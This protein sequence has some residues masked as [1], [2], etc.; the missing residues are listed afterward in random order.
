MDIID[1]SVSA[2]K[3]PK[4]LFFLF[5]FKQFLTNPL[6]ISSSPS[7]QDAKVLTP[8]M[9]HQ[10]TYSYTK[11]HKW[12][13]HDTL[14][15]FLLS[16]FRKPCTKSHFY[17]FYLTMFHNGMQK[18]IRIQRRKLQCDTTKNRPRQPKTCCKFMFP[19]CHFLTVG[20]LKCFT[21]N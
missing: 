7:I 11:G 4:C 19:A 20:T 14:F 8:Q 21:M 18:E 6:K 15:L 17:V 5:F 3:R 10:L 13:S 1:L 12:F 16:V 2:T 9:N